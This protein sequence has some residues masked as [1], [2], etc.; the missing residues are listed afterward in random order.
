[1]KI[2]FQTTTRLKIKS[3][4]QT[5]TKSADYTAKPIA[6]QKSYKPNLKAE[7]PKQLPQFEGRTGPLN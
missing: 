2:D 7:R 1:M 5:T 6:K 3:Y 4:F